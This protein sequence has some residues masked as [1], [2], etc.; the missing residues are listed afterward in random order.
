MK[1][2]TSLVL[3]VVLC[4]GMFAGCGKNYSVNESTVFI[5]KNSKIVSTDVEEFSDTYDQ[6]ALESYINDAINEYTQENGKDSVKLNKLTVEDGKAVLTIEYASAKDYMNFNGVELFEGSVVDA[7]AAGYT[8]DVDFAAVSDMNATACSKNDIIDSSDLKVVIF[9]GTGNIN[10][11]GKIVYASVVNT[12]LADESTIAIAQGFNLLG[13]VIEETQAT[14]STEA[15]TESEV[16]EENDTE[17]VEENMGSVDEDDLTQSTTEE[18]EVE[19][20]FEEEASEE[21]VT[22]SNVYTYVIYK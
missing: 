18:P 7:L 1:K 13:Q 8:F 22:Y 21:T 15:D 2:F 14:E 16:A 11:D 9:K 6:A 10:V 5:L 4:I 12:K 3:V 19:F 20:E 17:V